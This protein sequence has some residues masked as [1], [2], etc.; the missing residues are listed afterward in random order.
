M[1]VAYV[2]VANFEVLLKIERS[3]NAL[4]R[5]HLLEDQQPFTVGAKCTKVVIYCTA[6]TRNA[7]QTGYMM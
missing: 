6:L 7:V 3:V 1:A 4:L 2:L 5:P